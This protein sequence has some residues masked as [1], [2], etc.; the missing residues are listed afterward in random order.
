[1]QTEFIIPYADEHYEAEPPS[2]ETIAFDDEI[3]RFIFGFW[4]VTLP[5]VDIAFE[6]AWVLGSLRKFRPL[7]QLD[8]ERCDSSPRASQGLRL[9]PLSDCRLVILA[10][11]SCA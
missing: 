7:F 8:D 4:K 10:T 3:D 5:H 9:R 6:L 1:M 2:R 11:S